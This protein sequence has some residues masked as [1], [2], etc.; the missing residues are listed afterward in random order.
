MLKFDSKGGFLTFPRQPDE[1]SVNSNQTDSLGVTNV[2]WELQRAGQ[3]L[4][5]GKIKPHVPSLL[6]FE[7]EKAG[8]VFHPVEGHKNGDLLPYHD[9]IANNAESEEV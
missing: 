7:L 5:A 8:K 4:G 6:L 9:T 2:L 3:A 1:Q